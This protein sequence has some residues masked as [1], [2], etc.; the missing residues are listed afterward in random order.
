MKTVRLFLVVMLLALASGHA[1]AQ[2]P[3]GLA[4]PKAD[5]LQTFITK[6]CWK[7]I[8]PIRL[9]GANW[10][11]GL[12]ES[13]SSRP[14]EAASHA[15]C[16]CKS[17]TG[18][19]PTLGVT[20]GYWQPARI[21][22]VVRK[23]YCHPS[24]GGLD[25]DLSVGF[26]ARP[27]GG[28]QP[29]KGRGVAKETGFYNWH[30][31]YFPVLAI[32]KMFNGPACNPDGFSEFDVAA[33]SFIYPNWYDT[34]FQ[35]FVQ[36]EVLLFANPIGYAGTAMDCAYTA[37]NWKPLDSVFWGA[38][39]WGMNLPWIGSLGSNPGM[40]GGTSLIAARAMA[41]TARL[42]LSRRTMGNDAYCKAQPMPIMK[43]SQYKL[44]ML[45]PRSEAT[46]SNPQP[47]SLS[48]GNASQV[49]QTDPTSLTNVFTGSCTHPIGAPVVRWGAWRHI[50]AVGEDAIYLEWKWTDCCIGFTQ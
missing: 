26:G 24:L 22:E 37:A 27:V 2:L 30:I 9:M 25:V 44:Q 48:P 47:V 43:K 16:A 14:P 31:Y 39:C 40:V 32:I 8:F 12:S 49:P 35:A 6:V 21:I 33:S 18:G 5:P 19:I 34:T 10:N 15:L 17:S 13:G 7:A 45:F 28:M 46:A 50:P 4:C 42:G 29:D 20:L 38:G 41:L 36:P 11:F 1:H 3:S 23:P